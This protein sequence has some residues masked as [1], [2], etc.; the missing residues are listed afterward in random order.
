MCFVA[1]LL[2]VYNGSLLS[3]RMR[4]VVSDT[5]YWAHIPRANATSTTCNS[6]EYASRLHETASKLCV[7]VYQLT[8]AKSTDIVLNIFRMVC[9]AMA[10]NDCRRRNSGH[11]Q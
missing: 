10:G 2:S 4:P 8:A 3:A 6:G 11:G 7:C 1:A 5:V 9:D